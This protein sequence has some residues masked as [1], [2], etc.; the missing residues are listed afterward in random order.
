MAGSLPPEVQHKAGH[1]MG[2][3]GARPVRDVLV[4]GRD[5]LS[6]KPLLIQGDSRLLASQDS[7]SAAED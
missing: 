3:R 4:R 1:I 6:S 7:W 2:L 5:S